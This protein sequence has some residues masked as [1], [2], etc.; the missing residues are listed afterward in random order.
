[1]VGDILRKHVF[2]I[3][4]LTV[5]C[6]TIRSQRNKEVLRLEIHSSAQLVLC[7]RFDQQL[8][9]LNHQVGW[10]PCTTR[11]A[12]VAVQ[13]WEHVAKPTRWPESH[14]ER[15]A[16]EIYSRT[17]WESS[18]HL[19]QIVF[20]ILFDLYWFFNWT[21]SH[22]VP[23]QTGRLCL[24]D[25]AAEGSGTFAFDWASDHSHKWWSAS[26]G[27]SHW[28]LWA[29]YQWSPRAI[30][31]LHHKV[32][33]QQWL[34]QKIERTCHM[35]FLFVWLHLLGRNFGLEVHEWNAPSICPWELWP[36]LRLQQVPLETG[37][38]GWRWALG[39][40]HE[41]REYLAWNAH[42][43]KHRHRKIMKNR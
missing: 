19:F 33:H 13:R 36:L 3:K 1:M 21:Q 20:P 8:G 43:K 37:L 17:S 27:W 30:A 38:I 5:H 12:A 2:P 26:V 41:R 6:Q 42:G 4:T 35:S 22:K 10:V 25:P 29:R 39:W 24:L 18:D 9:A 34:L 28:N 32:L 23:A 11:L 15:A 40:L 14:L 7:E 16:G 31:W